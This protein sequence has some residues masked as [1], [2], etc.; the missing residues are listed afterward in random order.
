MR[1]SSNSAVQNQ[2]TVFKKD[3]LKLKKFL[4]M[5]KKAL[6]TAHPGAVLGKAYI[7]AKKEYKLEITVKDQK[8]L[9]MRMRWKL[10]K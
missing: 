10:D 9:F 7:N 2:I 8:L 5:S 3:I 4:M 6:E 1:R